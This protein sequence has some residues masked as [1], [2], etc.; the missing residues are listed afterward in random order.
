MKKK[1]F[2]REDVFLVLETR[3]I[4]SIAESPAPRQKRRWKTMSDAG[5]EK[6]EEISAHEGKK[7]QISSS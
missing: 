5:G 3:G 4:R 1:S 2:G 7:S 6:Q